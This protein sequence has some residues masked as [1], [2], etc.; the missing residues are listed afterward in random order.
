MD[1]KPGFYGHMCNQPCLKGFYGW[2]CGGACYPNC[3]VEECDPVYGCKLTNA[4]IIPR[5]NS[6]LFQTSNTDISRVLNATET[7]DAISH[8]SVL[9]VT[10]NNSPQNVFNSS[11]SLQ[12]LAGIICL[13]LFIILIKLFVKS[14]SRKEKRGNDT[15]NTSK[16]QLE[17]EN[18]TSYDTVSESLR[19]IPVYQPL[20][21][22]YDEINE[23][24]QIHCSGSI[25]ESN[26]CEKEHISTEKN[27]TDTQVNNLQMN[28]IVVEQNIKDENNLGAF[29]SEKNQKSDIKEKGLYIDVI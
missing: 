7:Y 29:A 8:Q 2:F 14:K 24:I 25:R 28:D 5:T 15:D 21:A 4:D 18:H 10:D 12:V 22:E 23:K 11:Y 27:T 19:T 3:S 9:L 17:K 26:D 13:S 16:F 20:K 1:C 6:D